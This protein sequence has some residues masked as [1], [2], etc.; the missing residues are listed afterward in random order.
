MIPK[1]NTGSLFGQ[2]DAQIPLAH[3]IRPRTLKEVLGQDHLKFLN[4]TKGEVLNTLSSPESTTSAIIYGPPGCGKTTLAHIIA[5]SSG[6]QLIC[7][8]GAGCSV[9]DI[10]EVTQ[11]GRKNLELGAKTIVLLD[12]IH[13]F[14]KSQQDTLLEPTEHGTFR[15]LGATTE[16]PFFGV[17]APLLSRCVLVE[18][19]RLSTQNI[20]DI[21]KRASKREFPNLEICDEGVKHIAQKSN[22]DARIA[23]NLL[24]MVHASAEPNVLTG[25]KTIDITTIKSLVYKNITH[26]DK[27]GNNHYDQISAYI[28]SM[29]GSDPDASLYWLARLLYS[30]EDP[31]FIARRLVIHAAEDVGLADPSAIQ[32][33]IAAQRAVETIGLPEARIPLAMATLH[34]AL[35]PKS[36][37]SCAGIKR[38]MKLIENSAEFL[39]EVPAHLKDSHYKSAE[40]LGHG[41][42]Y[43]FPHNFPDGYVKQSYLPE[44]LNNLK[45]NLYEPSK[46]GYEHLMYSKLL[47]RVQQFDCTHGNTQNTS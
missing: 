1:E 31:L 19:K 32:S 33:A 15:L 45:L 47:E 11:L 44:E 8:N 10:R 39:G 24:E 27:Q 30:G 23:L 35:A 16:N 34:I 22:G 2:G 5:Q 29:R 20:I 37:S 46:L 42:D 4:S 17:S 12:E 28:K 25:N 36:N 7:L 26:Y 18:L 3:K 40:T 9:G 38:A 6:A 43:Q 41:T 13:R 21:L 14:N